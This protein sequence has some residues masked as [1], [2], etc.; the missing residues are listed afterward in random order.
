MA[1]KSLCLSTTC[2]H[3]LSISHGRGEGACG[4]MPTGDKIHSLNVFQSFPQN[5]M[6]CRTFQLYHLFV[7]FSLFF[8]Y[9]CKNLKKTQKTEAFPFCFHVSRLTVVDQSFTK[10]ISVLENF[11]HSAKQDLFAGLVLL[12]RAWSPKLEVVM[13]WAQQPLLVFKHQSKTVNRKFSQ[14][15]SLSLLLSAFTQQ[16]STPV[17]STKLRQFGI[18]IL[19][20]VV[21]VVTYKNILVPEES[22]PASL[23][24][25]DQFENRLIGLNF[26]AAVVSSDVGSV[27]DLGIFIAWKTS[28]LGFKTPQAAFIGNNALPPTRCPDIK[29]F[30]N[31]P[32]TKLPLNLPATTG[33]S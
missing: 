5:T 29:N 20:K 15:Q 21:H 23:L 19:V 10:K 8:F 28:F 22:F 24:L 31:R 32:Y 7:L 25:F 33:C 4:Q 11:K 2:P 1:L 13:L 9:F 16:L 30:P 27:N 12:F 3:A 18:F 17:S 14:L 26:P 6:C